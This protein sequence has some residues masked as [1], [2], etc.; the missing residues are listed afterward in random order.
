[1][2]MKIEINKTK[3]EK[4]FLAPKTTEQEILLHLIENG[5]VSI[6]DFPYISGFRTRISNLKKKGVEIESK[7][8]K[9]VN[10][11]GNSYFFV[12]HSIIDKNTAVSTYENLTRLNRK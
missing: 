7:L 10:K 5:K 2:E 8:I 11:Y 1:M 3:K 4:S 12:I 6:F 9:G